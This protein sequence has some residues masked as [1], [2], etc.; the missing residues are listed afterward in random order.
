RYA[1]LLG[2]PKALLLDLNIL[3]GQ[4]KP[5]QVTPFPTLMQTGTESFQ[6]VR[7]AS[8]GAPRLTIY[9]ESSVNP[10]DLKYFP[11]ALASMVQ[12]RRTGHGYE[13]SSPYSFTL[14][15]PPGVKEIRIDGLLH[16]PSRENVFLIPAGTHSVE[17]G[18]DQSPAFSTHELDARMLSISGNLLSVVQGIRSMSFTY[19]SET[20]ALVSL[21]REATA[22]SVDGDAYPFTPLRGND[23]FTLSL[24]PGKHSV[25]V[26]LGDVVSYGVSLTSFWSSNAIAVF[27]SCAVLLLL[28][29]YIVLKIVRRRYA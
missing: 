27:G 15:L 21:N 29:M 4:R 22:L 2:D 9:S 17:A 10:Q 18:G 13:V 1:G 26:V 8:L 3:A 14:K 24:P 20:R 25:H 16:S 12:Y 6:L 5:D 23:C 7:A 28:A 19:E 11:F